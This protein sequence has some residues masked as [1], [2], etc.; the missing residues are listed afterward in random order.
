MLGRFMGVV[1]YPPIFLLPQVL[2]NVND[3]SIKPPSVLF[4][5]LACRF[6]PPIGKAGTVILW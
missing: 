5:H 3:D 6:L 2:Y 1:K 4:W